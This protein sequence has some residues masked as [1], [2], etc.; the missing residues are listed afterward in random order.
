MRRQ[1]NTST[2]DSLYK[3]DMVH[4]DTKNSM[5]QDTHDEMELIRRGLNTLNDSGDSLQRTD[6]RLYEAIS[7]EELNTK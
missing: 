5:T 3:I 4:S 6:Q 2:D 7:Q 1:L